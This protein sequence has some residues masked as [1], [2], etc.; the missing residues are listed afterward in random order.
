MAQKI[1]YLIAA[2]FLG[3]VLYYACTNTNGELSPPDSVDHGAYRVGNGFR[4]LVGAANSEIEGTRDGMQ[5]TVNRRVDL[6]DGRV[7]ES[8]K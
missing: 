2:V 4:S 5:D 3:L 8:S 7:D 1:S 6:Q